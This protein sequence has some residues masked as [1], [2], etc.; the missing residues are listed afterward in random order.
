MLI[1]RET[2]IKVE[3]LWWFTVKRSWSFFKDGVF[4]VPPK[5]ELDKKDLL[6]Y[7]AFQKL[8]PEEMKAVQEAI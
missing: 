2:A 6:R 5:V 4:S 1:T 3:D 8:T 7:Q